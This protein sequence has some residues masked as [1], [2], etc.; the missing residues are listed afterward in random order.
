MSSVQ[1]HSS[2]IETGTP[3]WRAAARSLLPVC[4][5]VLVGCTEDE[6]LSECTGPVTISVST[7]TTPL[8]GWTPACRVSDLVVQEAGIAADV[9]EIVTDGT[10]QIDPGVRYGIVPP[11]VREQED[12]ETLLVGVTYNVAVGRWT[13]SGLEVIGVRSFTP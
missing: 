10:N 2:P 9:W 3:V 11:G 7:G 4:L 8:F 5:A 1:Q 6:S 12:P 13:G